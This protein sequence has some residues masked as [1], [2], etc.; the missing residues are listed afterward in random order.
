MIHVTREQVARLAPHIKP[1]YLDAFT[2]ADEVLARYGVN[3]N[4]LRV[5][6][7]M[8]QAC[9]ETGGFT[10]LTESLTY[11]HAERIAAIWPYQRANP[12]PHQFKSAEEAAPYV[13]N[14]EKLAN[15]VY[16]GRM[17]NVN[18]GDGWK[19]IGRGMI[20]LTGRESY[21]KFGALLGIDLEGNPDLAIDPRYSLAIAA[22]EWQRSG[23][24]A[25]ADANDVKAVTKAIN[26]GYIGL[27]ER[28]ALL[29][30]TK[31]IWG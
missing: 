3:E 12:K 9:H 11:T 16:A 26:G 24:N 27:D 6:H 22:V 21:E 28:R 1:I 15:R 31:A 29:A 7:F 2:N 10:I 8:A 19:F 30:Q 13:R 14:A 4:A 5:A 25:K 23:C 18:P 20:Q 17:G